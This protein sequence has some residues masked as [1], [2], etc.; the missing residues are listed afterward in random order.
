MGAANHSAQIAWIIY[1]FLSFSSSL[2]LAL[3]LYLSSYSFFFYIFLYFFH[4]QTT[5]MQFGLNSR[6]INWLARV[7]AHVSESALF[8][9]I[10]L[11]ATTMAKARRI[12]HTLRGTRVSYSTTRWFSFDS[13][14]TYPRY[15]YVTSSIPIEEPCGSLRVSVSFLV[16]Y[17]V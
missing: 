6:Y 1:P 3:F 4:K 13:R 11:T 10:G 15:G 9:I 5:T 8:W 16:L 2:S 12:N 7:Y 17:L 14:R